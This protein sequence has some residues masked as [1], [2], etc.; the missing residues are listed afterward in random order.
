MPAKIKP[1][2]ARKLAETLV[3]GEPNR[4]KIA[5]TSAHDTV[6]ELV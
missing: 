4:M 3:R 2:Q 6:H 1:S 5:L